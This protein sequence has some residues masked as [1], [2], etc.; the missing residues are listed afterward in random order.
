MLCYYIPLA[1]I[2]TTTLT[3]AARNSELF[4][5]RL[6]DYFSC[7]QSGHDPNNPCDRKS[8]SE[9]SHPDLAVT[10]LVLLGIFPVVNL[11]YAINIRELKEKFSS[12]LGKTKVVSRNTKRTLSS[13]SS[14]SIKLDTKMTKN[15]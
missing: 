2:D 3:I 12:C 10:A 7:E 9:I 1:V 15:V 13:L 8:L 5:A 6:R 11:V 4:A 14:V